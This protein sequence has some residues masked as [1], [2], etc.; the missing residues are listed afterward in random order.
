MTAVSL[1]DQVVIV[2]GARRGLGRA[3]ALELARCGAA[4]VV[5]GTPTSPGLDEVVAEI[6][7]GG[8]TAVAS[9]NDV[10][11]PEGGRAV[12]QDALERFGRLDAVVNNAG[13]LRA[14]WFEDLPE[15]QIEDIFAI[16]L[17]AVFHTTQAA[18]PVLRKA[19]YGRIV[20]TSS[21]TAF[22]MAALAHYAAAKAGI[23]GLTKSLALEGADDGILVNCVLPNA[24]TPAMASDPIPGFEEDTR[25]IAAYQAV[26]GR[27]GAELVAPLV[28]YLA[29]SSCTLTGE[30]LSALGGR[31]ARVFYGVTEGWFSPTD[32]PVSASDV[33]EHIDEITAIDGPFLVPEKI[34]DE[35]EAVAALFTAS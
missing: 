19:R 2:T 18:F 9:P 8:G 25:F 16:H 20:N 1:A 10:T 15:A 5:N 30:A 23:I 21:N 27:Y 26:A 33:A 22:G 14:G 32:Q 12:V 17:K 7:A 24:T 29:S 35:Y 31:Y 28:A 11:T 4:V 3:Y 13:I 34:R 6:E